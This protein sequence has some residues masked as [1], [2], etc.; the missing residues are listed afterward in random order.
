MGAQA[1]LSEELPPGTEFAGYRIDA[2]IGTG[3]AGIVYRARRTGDDGVV[4]IK[5]LRSAAAG[6][7]ILRQRFEHEGRVIATI[8][9]PNLVPVLGVGTS[10]GRPYLV[11]R[12]MAGGSLATALHEGALLPVGQ[13]IRLIEQVSAG[14]DA[15]H[16]AGI[17]HRDVK[18]ANVLLER[19]GA[20]ALGDFGLA[21]APRDTVLTR[22]GQALG[23]IDYLAP[24]V[25]RGAAASPASDVYALGCLAFAV[26]SGAPPFAGRGYMQALFAH[27]EESPSDPLATRADAPGA[28]GVVVL[29]ALEK[30]PGARPP[31]A[32]A[33][34]QA[35]RKAMSE[36]H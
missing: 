36:P 23:T 33:Y 11:S 13:A 8:R 14:L 17:V 22:P 35:L 26:L 30:D 16:V 1:G 31:T 27:L 28:V 18:P 6:D 20:A 29:Q 24:E 32:G 2:M 19:D 10:D 9:H 4:A 25:I 3:A 7:P 34:A 21:R 5:V 15:L 12:Y